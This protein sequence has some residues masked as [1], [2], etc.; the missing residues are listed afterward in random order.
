MKN[1][2]FPTLQFFKLWKNWSLSHLN[3]P[4]EV[5]RTN[6]K[7]S[8]HKISG[9]RSEISLPE[10][11]ESGQRGSET[12]GFRGFRHLYLGAVPEVSEAVFRSRLIA[13]TFKWQNKQ[14]SNKFAVL[15]SKEVQSI[16]SSGEFSQGLLGK[17]EFHGALEAKQ[18][19]WSGHSRWLFS[20]SLY[21]LCPASAGFT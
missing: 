7:S 6:S 8:E 21:I 11:P 1:L 12:E 19:V 16:T 10:I 9:A 4:P 20:W 14:F 13:K 15:Y 17:N 18:D 3:F 2:E 5:I